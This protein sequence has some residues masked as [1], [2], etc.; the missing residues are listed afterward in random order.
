MTPTG[1]GAATVQIRKHSA[2]LKGIGTKY[3]TQLQP[4]R[5]AAFVGP[6]DIYT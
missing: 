1:D 3:H 5:S 4:M 6:N 2:S